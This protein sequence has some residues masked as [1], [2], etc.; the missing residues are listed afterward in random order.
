[1]YPFNPDFKANWIYFTFTGYQFLKSKLTKLPERIACVAAGSGIEAI[2]M[3]KIF[4]DAK[5]ITITDIDKEVVSNAFLNVKNALPNFNVIPRIGSLCSPLL[6]DPYKFDL[7]HGNVPNLICDDG[8]DLSS[9]S[10]KGTFVKESLL[11]DIPEEYLKWALG[12]QYIFLKGAYNV[13]RKNG[14]IITI[15][16]GRFP[17]EIVEKLFSDCNLKLAPEFSVGFKWQTQPEPDYLGYAELEGKY[18]IEFDFF[19]YE[20]ALEI[21]KQNG[22]ENPTPSYTGNEVKDILADVLVSAKEAL[23][24][25]GKGIKCGHTVHMFRGVRIN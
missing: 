12:T 8:K 16:G 21:L 23:E 1:M 25:H 10:D 15:V 14:S 4:P 20:E 24:L 9:G 17:L 3:V 13:L 11:T 2:G 22:I 7:I 5:S 19:L 18:G 6:G